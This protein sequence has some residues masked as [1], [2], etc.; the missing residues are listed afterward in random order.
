MSVP[1]FYKELNIPST[2]EGLDQCLIVVKE[3]ELFLKLD[4]EKLLSL[5]TCIVESV[6]NA[7]IHG[8]KG[9]RNLSVRVLFEITDDQII[10]EV[11]DQ[12]NGFDI[13]LIP[14]PLLKD[15]L[16]KES[17]RG[18]FFIRNL[19]SCCITKGNGN[20]LFIIISR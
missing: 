12:G 5:Q 4:Y 16:R 8:N 3:I 13:D 15:N 17:G 20:I 6:E 18:I 2:I 9:D 19:S 10:I 14:S 7:I 1:L 11:E